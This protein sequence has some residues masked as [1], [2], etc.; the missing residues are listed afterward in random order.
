M[1][2]VMWAPLGLTTLILLTGLQATPITTDNPGTGKPSTVG[3][4]EEHLTHAPTTGPSTVSSIL[5]EVMA[6]SRLLSP[7]PDGAYWTGGKLVRYRVNNMRRPTSTD[8]VV[9]TWNDGRVGRPSILGLTRADEEQLREGYTYCLALNLKEAT[10]Q[11]RDCSDRLPYACLITPRQTG[12]TNKVPLVPQ[13]GESTEVPEMTAATTEEDLSQTTADLLAGEMATSQPMSTTPTTQNV[14]TL[15]PLT[16]G[17]VST[18]SLTTETGATPSTASGMTEILSGVAYQTTGMPTT[19][20]VLSGVAYETTGIPTTAT[21]VNVVKHETTGM[22]TT[23]KLLW[24]VAHHTTGMPTTARVMSGVAHHTTGMPKTTAKLLSGVS[25]ETT[26]MPTT[27]KMLN[28]VAHETTGM[29]TT[30]K[31]LGS[32]AHQTTGL[33]TT[34]RV[35]DEETVDNEAF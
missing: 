28:A 10:W 21:A 25:Y 1:R 30:A 13:F 8:H 9:L 32:V 14:N 3:L 26:G 35:L 20:K 2:F 5:R 17:A 33:P 34:A 31:V 16:T 19:A 11:A 24:G 4:L 6:L 18:Q 15:T 12:F 27:A 29:P 7:L 23:N 22:P